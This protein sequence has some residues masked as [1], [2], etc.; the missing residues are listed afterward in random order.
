MKKRRQNP[1]KKP[2]IIDFVKCAFLV[3]FIIIIIIIIIIIKSNKIKMKRFT[4]SEDLIMLILKTYLV[5]TF[6]EHL[7]LAQVVDSE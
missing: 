4:Y 2:K 1:E 5:F 6:S 7:F 3:L